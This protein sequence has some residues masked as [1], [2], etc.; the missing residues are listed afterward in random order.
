LEHENREG[1]EMRF[2]SREIKELFIAWLMISIAF[3]IAISGLSLTKDFL[4]S[5]VAS[6]F[7]VGVGFVFHELAH[8][9]MAQKYYCFA[10]FYYNPFMLV[11]AVLIS[12]LGVIF[13]APGAVVIS[14][15]TIHRNYGKI[16]A[17]GPIANLVISVLFFIAFIFYNITI[18]RYG[19]L[20]NA[21]L[22]L[23][24][25]IPIANFDGLKIMAWS[26]TAYWT[27][28]VVSAMLVF[29]GYFL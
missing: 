22:A 6:A 19:F 3:A 24:N 8:K 11:F 15:H 12:F 29:L 7:T 26:K 28:L 18:L 2:S 14:G 23:F 13:A 16:S 5:V 20:I 25:M 17:A 27:I 4:L 21:W 9:Y 1:I 10:E